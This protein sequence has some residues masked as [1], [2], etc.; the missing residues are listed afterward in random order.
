[1]FWNDAGSFAFSVTAAIVIG[2]LIGVATVW[3]RAKFTNPVYD[4]VVSFVV[5]FVAFIPAE[6]VGASGVLAVVVTGLYTG[7]H[8]SRRFSATARMN[9]R[10]NWR[11]LQFVIENGVF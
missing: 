3:V 4:T 11:T 10:L 5:P 6:E 7:H 9:E 8:S 1:A 2:Y